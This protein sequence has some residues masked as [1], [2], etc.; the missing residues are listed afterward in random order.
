MKIYALPAMENI[1]PTVPRAVALGI[2]D[3][4][5]LG[6]RQVILAATQNLP[7]EVSRCVYTFRPETVTTKPTDGQLDTPTHQ[8]ELL[9]SMGVEELFQV[10]FSAV[11]ALSPAEFVEQV[12]HRQLHAVQVACGY[13]YRFGKNGVGDASTLT[14][15]CA[16]WGIQVVV[17]P[18]VTVEDTP[19]SSTAIRQAL[20]NGD[21][22]GARRLLGRNYRL[23][24]PVVSGQHLGQKL[25]MPTINQPLPATLYPPRYGVY[26]SYVEVEGDI[27]PAV[28]NIGVRPTVGTDAPLAETFILHYSGDLYGTVPTVYPLE[29]LRPEQTFPSLDAL[30]EQV[31]QDVAR[32]EALFAPPIQQEIRA[33]LFDFDDTLG[34]RDAAFLQGLDR[35]IRYYFPELTEEEVHRRQE[36][37]FHYNRAGYGNV[38]RYIDLVQHFLAKWGRPEVAPEVALRRLCDGFSADYPLHPDGISTLLTLRKQGYKL[39]LITNGSSYPQNRKLDSSG[40]RPYFDLVTVCGEEG[41][42]K[43]HPLIFRRTAARLGVPVECCLYVGDHPLNDIAAAQAVGMSAVRKD[44]GHDPNHPFHTLPLPDS[45]VIHHIGD[46]PALL[47]RMVEGTT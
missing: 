3:G 45:P 27:L 38:I 11:Q 14:A 34:D 46:L 13:N 26:A 21:M 42:Q 37:M 8:Q 41:L 36:E 19:I 1:L 6:H 24:L 31:T 9:V 43:P 23:Q 12:L 33:I 17:V 15:L 18:A 22:A 39:G 44:A 7:D 32:T 10:D 30:K 40:L 16:H 35:F 25:G 4:L 5:H 47:T 29:F 2:F 28:T 20:A